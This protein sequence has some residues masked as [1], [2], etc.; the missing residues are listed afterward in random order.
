MQPQACVFILKL[1]EL[2]IAL[3]VNNAEQRPKAVKAQYSNKMLIAVLAVRSHKLGY[4]AVP[5]TSSVRFSVQQSARFT[6]I[7]AT[8]RACFRRAETDKRRQSLLSYEVATRVTSMHS[9]RSG[10]CTARC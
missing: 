2:V 3:F 10:V 7:T 1:H 5:I 9:R 6:F 8:E 4:N